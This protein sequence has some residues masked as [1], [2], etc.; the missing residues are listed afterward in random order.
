MRLNQRSAIATQYGWDISEVTQYQPSETN[1]LHPRVKVYDLGSTYAVALKE[2]E[3]VPPRI[4]EHF[5]PF[6]P[7][8]PYRG[9]VVWNTCRD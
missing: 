2:G 1:K 6:T 3:P 9:Y 7:C 5:G 8:A 4:V